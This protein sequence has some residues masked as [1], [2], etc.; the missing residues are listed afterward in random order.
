MVQMAS[1]LFTS[2][3]NEAPF[4]L[5]WVA[6]HLTIGFERII[7]VSNDCDDGTEEILAALAANQVIE[8]IPQE[9]ATCA[10]PQMLAAAK[11][12]P[13]IDKGDWVMWL[14]CDEFLNVKI[15]QRNLPSLLELIGDKRGML[16]NWRMF[17]DS[18][19][20]P[21]PGRFVSEHFI[22]CSEETNPENIR[23]KTLFQKGRGV[24]GFQTKG[25]HRPLIGRDAELTAGHF[26]NGTGR[27][28][29]ASYGKHRQWVRG[30]DVGHDS[31]VLATEMGFGI[32]Q[33]NHYAVRTAEMFWLKSARGDGWVPKQSNDINLRHTATFYAKMN[34]NDVEDASILFWSEATN[35]AVD[36]LL[37]QPGVKQAV[38]FAN[39]RVTE[40][41]VHFKGSE[42]SK[43]H[44]G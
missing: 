14:D 13:L 27:A 21:F 26:L 28:L 23:I 8:H 19:Q 15:G 4:I 11:A 43:M 32:A 7:V 10:S 18:R 31:A 40:K 44:F 29:D 1:V 3:K 6:Y 12:D 38:T 2:V 9:V 25:M 5:E 35:A 42:F 37:S 16:I 39:A 20:Y 41:L 22:M 34:S 33:I 30:R 36:E 24:L 17:G